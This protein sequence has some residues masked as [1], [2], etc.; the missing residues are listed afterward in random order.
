MC[1]RNGRFRFSRIIFVIQP[2]CRQDKYTNAVRWQC[3]SV[4]NQAILLNAEP[5]AVAA[6][7]T[8][9]TGQIIFICA[10]NRTLLI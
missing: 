5:M 4:L 1:R 6:V 10:F 8:I 2:C 7:N 9:H 3:P